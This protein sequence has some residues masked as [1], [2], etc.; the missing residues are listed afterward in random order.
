MKNLVNYETR[1]QI[2]IAT[3]DDGKVNAMSVAMMDAI[4]HALDQAESDN[5]V[6]ILT[7]RQG[8]FSAGFDLSVF[9]QGPER[10][11]EMIKTG[12]ELAERV[13]GFPMP[14]VTACNG[15]AYPMGAFLMLSADARVGVDG[16]YNIGMNEVAIGITVPQFAIEIAKH[17]LTPAYFNRA[18]CNAEMFS[19][20]DAVKAGFLDLVVTE[21]ELLEV[22]IQKAE[23]L[24]KLDLNSYRAT[25][26]KA[27]REAF[28][29]VRRAIESELTL[30]V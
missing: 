3:M 24:C 17:R 16:P 6:V 29:A 11:R 15:H 12:A 27:K 21:E 19:P 30:A 20:A 7:G 25:K 8:I 28:T 26:K 18:V 5:A 2:A 23:E 9:K 14:V 1:G 13:M 4:N 22:S 10:L